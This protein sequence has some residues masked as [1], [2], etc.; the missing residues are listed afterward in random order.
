M[1][2][3]LRLR[4]PLPV[5]SLWHLVLAWCLCVAIALQGFAAA[6][7]ALCPH[8]AGQLH[9]TAAHAQAEAAPVGSKAMGHEHH[10]HPGHPGH[11]DDSGASEHPVTGDHSAGC[12]QCGDCCPGLAP[13]PGQTLPTD[14]APPSQGL[15]SLAS[16]SPPTFLTGGTE[17]PPRHGA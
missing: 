7:Q 16:A 1:P 5:W 3:P 15:P 10:G 4:Q 8:A 13:M 12:S 9:A 11:A 17:R 14:Q 6:S 2:Q